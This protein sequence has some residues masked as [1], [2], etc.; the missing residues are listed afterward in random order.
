MAFKD[1][2]KLESWN[3]GSKQ[4]VEVKTVTI[5]SP[6]EYDTWFSGSSLN[7]QLYRISITYRCANLIA[8][9]IAGMPVYAVNK[10][11]LVPINSLTS[12]AGNFNKVMRGYIYGD[13]PYDFMRDIVIDLLMYGNAFIHPIYDTDSKR[14]VDLL[15]IPAYGVEVDRRGRNEKNAGQKYY[16]IAVSDEDTA[17]ITDKE[18]ILEHDEVV[19]IRLSSMSS[20]RDMGSPVVDLKVPDFQIASAAD[21]RVLDAVKYGNL[22]Q[23]AVIFQ[24]D[25]QLDEESIIGEQEYFEDLKSEQPMIH[26]A[27]KDVKQLNP[28]AQNPDMA[29]LREQEDYRMVQRF[30]IPAPKAGIRTTE[31]Y[32]GIEQ[33]NRMYWK[34]CLKPIARNIENA[35][36]LAFV[37]SRTHMVRFN[38]R[39]LLRGDYDTMSNIH[40]KAAGPNHTAVNKTNEWRADMGLDPVEGGDVLIPSA[41]P[42]MNT[43]GQNDSSNAT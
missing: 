27:I 36:T 15:R 7:K 18:T 4:P 23:L 29:S 17:F 32:S 1:L 40:E 13:T 39:E 11:T 31:W 35:F 16:T 25:F 8:N 37:D 22:N 34:D 41:V 42:D 26:S 24:D 10:K 19:H 33:L 5:G 2:F 6:K 43:G 3:Y 38:E 9:D 21:S 20:N 30:G 28:S 12:R 14:L